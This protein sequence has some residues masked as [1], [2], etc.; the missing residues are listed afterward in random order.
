MTN[1]QSG[2]DDQKP[3]LFGNTSLSVATKHG[4]TDSPHRTSLRA[5]IRCSHTAVSTLSSCRRNPPASP[6]PPPH[7]QLVR[8]TL[9]LHLPPRRTPLPTHLRRRLHRKLLR[10]QTRKSP[11]HKRPRDPSR[12]SRSPRT[13]PRNPQ[14]HQQRCLQESP[15]YGTITIH[16]AQTG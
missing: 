16:K 13:S 4:M 8:R 1:L 3:S 9:R 2:L 11:T 7:P 5:T 14:T 6:L 10:P 12:F 15:G